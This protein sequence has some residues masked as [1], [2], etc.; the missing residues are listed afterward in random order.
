MKGR[1]EGGKKRM[2]KENDKS[3][4]K[5][6]RKA[7]QKDTILEFKGTSWNLLG[8]L[9][10]RKFSIPKQSGGKSCWDTGKIHIN[11]CIKRTA[12]ANLHFR[13]SIINKTRHTQLLI[14][15]YYMADTVL[16]TSIKAEI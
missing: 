11:S 13:T 2:E 12:R 7:L 5:K 10:N 3:L 9:P 15:K 6:I 1:E 16:G 14:S 4:F 8:F